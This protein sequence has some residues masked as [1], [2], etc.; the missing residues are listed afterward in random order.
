M[1]TLTN[2][3]AGSNFAPKTFEKQ[4]TNS[5]K[6]LLPCLPFEQQPTIYTLSEVANIPSAVVILYRPFSKYLLAA[7]AAL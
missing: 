6:V 1:D 3:G 4:L 7:T 2:F 5:T